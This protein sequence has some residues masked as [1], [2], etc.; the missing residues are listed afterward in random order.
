MCAD[1]QRK[2]S[3]NK[4]RGREHKGGKERTGRKE[5]QD[6]A[7]RKK[8]VDWIRGRR[9]NGIRETVRMKWVYK[10]FLPILKFHSDT[11]I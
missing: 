4:R 7:G 1:D 8:R 6:G 2:H 5:K 11:H 10:L 9:S 3:E